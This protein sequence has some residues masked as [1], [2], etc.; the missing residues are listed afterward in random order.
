MRWRNVSR[1]SEDWTFTVIS[2]PSISGPIKSNRRHYFW[3]AHYV[4][5]YVCLLA[6]VCLC[7]CTRAHMCSAYTYLYLPVVVHWAERACRSWHGLRFKCHN[8]SAMSPSVPRD[9][10]ETSGSVPT[11]SLWGERAFSSFIQTNRNKTSVMLTELTFPK[12]RRKNDHVIRWKISTD[13]IVKHFSQHKPTHL[14]A[15]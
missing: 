10:P 12:D 4:C 13:K 5:M 3:S 6:C 14:Y 2:T 11:V 8:V 9:M 1:R 7:A 15:C